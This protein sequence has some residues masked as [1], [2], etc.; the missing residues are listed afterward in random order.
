MYKKDHLTTNTSPDTTLA[1]PA[2]SRFKHVPV[3]SENT[4]YKVSWMISDKL[5]ESDEVL[6]GLKR[7]FAPTS[8]ISGLCLSQC[9]GKN[10]AS[11]RDG[12]TYQRDVVADVKAMR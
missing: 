11:G 1:K 6:S 4:P 10:L 5:L 7:R 8:P 3:T 12:K 2:A 9:P